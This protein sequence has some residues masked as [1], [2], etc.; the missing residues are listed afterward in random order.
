MKFISTF[1]SVL[2]SV[3]NCFQQCRPRVEYPLEFD[4]DA[5]DKIRMGRRKVLFENVLKFNPLSSSIRQCA[6]MDCE[7]VLKTVAN[8][9]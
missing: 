7:N 3:P 1:F 2:C 4:V 9:T 8:S 5:G 6:D